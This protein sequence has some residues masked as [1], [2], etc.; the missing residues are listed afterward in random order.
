MKKEILNKIISK[1]HAD[2]F[3]PKI[4]LELEFYLTKNNQQIDDQNLIQDFIDELSFEIKKREIDLF[5]I[6]KERGLGQIEIK[7]NPYKNIDKLIADID[8][9]KVIS[10]DLAQNKSL[11]SDFSPTPFITDC[12]SAL[13]INISILDKNNCNL[14]VKNGEKESDLLLNSIAGLLINFPKNIDYFITSKS[15]ILRFDL[16]RNKELFKK[17]KF[18]SPINLSWG[19]DNRSCAIRITNNI[20]TPENR[21]ILIIS[22]LLK[23]SSKFDDLQ[24]SF[25]GSEEN[26]RLEFRIAD[27]NI[28]T[29][30]AVNKALEMV[31]DGIDKNLKPIEPIYGNAFDKKYE[32]LEKII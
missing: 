24:N 26:R 17:G 4:G 31:K 11:K 5:G 12:S 20:K 30:K 6:E 15:D 19:Y 27:A 23:N 29:M 2:F 22:S 21:Q 3:Y 25:V 1:F 13:Q 16:S 7:T 8:L 14:F 32:Y 28:D 18:T 10:Q 9:V